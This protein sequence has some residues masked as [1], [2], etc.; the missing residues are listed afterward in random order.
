MVELMRGNILEADVEAL[1]NTVNTVGVM[2]KG[3]ALQFR[4]AF[5]ANYDLYRRACK[6]SEVVPGR[7][8][9]VSTH[10][11]ENPRL[12]INFPTKRHWK[13]K[14]KVED[15]EAG[16]VDLVN[17]IKREHISSIAIPPLGCGNG[18]LDWDDIRPR[19]LNALAAVPSVKALLYSP[20]GAPGVDAMPVATKRPRMNNNRAAMVTLMLSYG[21]PGYRLTLLEIQKLAYFLQLAGQPL[22]LAFVKQ[23]YGPYA[24]NLN[25][26]LQRLEG[27]FIRG[28]GDRNRE[29]SVRVLPDAVNEAAEFLADD[30]ATMERIN[31]V[32]ELIEGFETPHG[33]ELLSTVHWVLQEDPRAKS[34]LNVAVQLVHSWNDRKRA[35]FPINHITVAHSHLIRS[36]LQS[37]TME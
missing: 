21:I 1:V 14:S 3:I 12:I 6:R 11:L 13:G 31:A 25:H 2:G 16:L 27:H 23:Q 19:I 24:E 26:F 8:L 35:V 5:P 37:G 34:D 18:G 17:V 36:R 29:A 33:M 20:D 32:S 30:N 9:V 28:Y 4:Q 15:I 7:M 10:R 22:N